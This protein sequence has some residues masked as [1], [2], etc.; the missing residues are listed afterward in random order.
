LTEKE[1]QMPIGDMM[2]ARLGGHADFADR[3]RIGALTLI[4]RDTNA[5][6]TISS[7]GLSLEEEPRAT[8]LPVFLNFHDML[9]FWRGK[10][11]RRTA[12]KSTRA[13]WMMDRE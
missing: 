1:K 2:T 5:N 12:G 4:V 9:D 7:V 6:G 3:V 8:S 11:Q 13:G 10:F